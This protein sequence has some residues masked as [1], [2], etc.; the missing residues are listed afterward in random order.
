MCYF[1]REKKFFF[2]FFHEEKFSK[3]TYTVDVPLITENEKYSLVPFVMILNVVPIFGWKRAKAH[4]Q[5]SLKC[6]YTAYNNKILKW[7]CDSI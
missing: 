5:F 7:L 2:S 4:S 3:W 6:I 1:Q